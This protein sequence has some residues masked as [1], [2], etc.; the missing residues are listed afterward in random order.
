MYAASWRALLILNLK[1]AS[2]S[3]QGPSLSNRVLANFLASTIHQISTKIPMEMHVSTPMVR[4]RHDCP[5]DRVD[6]ISTPAPQTWH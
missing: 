5:E 1:L 4:F 3:C 2:C 6:L